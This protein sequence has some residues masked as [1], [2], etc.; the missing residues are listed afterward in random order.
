MGTKIVALLKVFYIECTCFCLDKCVLY[1]M[2]NKADW[3]LFLSGHKQKDVVFVNLGYLSLHS[4]KL[5]CLHF[6][7]VYVLIIEA[8][9][10]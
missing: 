1:L 4:W 10:L 6:V 5:H 9:S 7:K 2:E 3:K 8:S